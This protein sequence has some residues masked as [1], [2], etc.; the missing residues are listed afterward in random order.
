[1]YSWPLNNVG[2]GAP[3]PCTVAYCWQGASP[4]RW[5]AD[6]HLFC[7]IYAFYTAYYNKLE[8]GNYFQIVSN[9]QKFFK[10]IYWEKSTYKW[11]YTIQTHVCLRVN[12]V[13]QVLVT[14][15]IPRQAPGSSPSP[16]CVFICFRQD[17]DVINACCCQHYTGR[18]IKWVQGWIW[19][20]APP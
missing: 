20:R 10:Y 1:M 13:S 17:C 7:T 14:E 12:W 11:T 18:L 8:K 2:F 5:T 4:I 9:L 16:S 3:T 6:K 15:A 19:G